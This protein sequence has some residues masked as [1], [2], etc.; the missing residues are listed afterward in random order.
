MRSSQSGSN[1]FI[2]RLFAEKKLINFGDSEQKVNYLHLK[3]KHA[4]SHANDEASTFSLHQTQHVKLKLTITSPKKPVQHISLRPNSELIIGRHALSDLKISG[5]RISDFHAKIRVSDEKVYIEDLHSKLGTVVD[6]ERLASG[7]S[8]ELIGKIS[9][10]IKNHQFHFDI[11]KRLPLAKP[12]VKNKQTKAVID[13]A[14]THLIN[15]H[16]QIS[17]WK[18]SPTKLTVTAIIDE[19]A[20]AKTIRLSADNPVLFHYQPGQ[21]I[22][23]HLNIGGQEVKRSYSIA[24]SPSRP[25]SLEITVKKVPGGLVSNWLHEQLRVGDRITVIGPMGR[26]SCFNHPAPKLLLIAAGSGV[27]PIMSMVRWL[28]DVG[29]HADILLLLSFRSPDD[30]IYRRELE[31]LSKR[32]SNLRIKTTLTAKDINKKEWP[33]A[34]GRLDKSLLKALAPD[35]RKREVFLCGPDSFMDEVGKTL[36]SLKL[37]PDQLHSESFTV[38]APMKTSVAPINA[39]QLK[40]RIGKFT[41]NFAK[42]GVR[43]VTEGDENLLQLANIYGVKIDSACL[44]GSCGECMVK[45]TG[46]DIVIGEHAG[47][48]ESEKQKGWVYSCCTYPKSDLTLDV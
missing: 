43:A 41:V 47:I 8:R 44:S 27:V 33:D 12:E 38:T 7:C 29:S 5:F 14:Y 22:T 17:T 1:P 9:V 25:Y 21:F 31:L 37:H 39:N 30:I 24:S 34:L 23:L 40:D 3:N 36:I 15:D 42:S 45:C 20:D 48:S 6:G 4:S 46:G 10:I 18:S 32:H 2:R 13:H 16:Q 26:F 35:F 19:T 11:P 28:T